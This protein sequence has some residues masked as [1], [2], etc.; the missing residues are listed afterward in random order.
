MEALANGGADAEENL[1]LACER[2]NSLKHTLPYG[3]FRQYAQAL[4]WEGEPK[5]LGPRDLESLMT[6]YLSTPDGEWFYSVPDSNVGT[7]RLHSLP[8]H[9][10]AVESGCYIAEISIQGTTSRRA[11]GDADFIVLAHRLMPQLVAELHILRAELA[12]ARGETQAT[13]DAA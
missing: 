3:N 8:S 11:T 7:V 9:E 10:L 5:R 6:A 1:T 4:F 12:E 2:C 13:E